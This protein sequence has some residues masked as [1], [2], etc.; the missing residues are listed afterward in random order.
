MCIPR[1][2]YR[3]KRPFEAVKAPLAGLQ[4]GGEGTVAK[5]GRGEW[6]QE[7]YK[8]RFHLWA[9]R[10]LQHSIHVKG[11]WQRPLCT[12]QLAG[13]IMKPK[14]QSSGFF[15][16]WQLTEMIQSNRLFLIGKVLTPTLHGK[17]CIA[18]FSARCHFP[19]FEVNM[20]SANINKEGAAP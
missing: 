13:S 15:F 10:Y 9:F 8:Q 5:E 20:M 18:F 14:H 12:Q 6:D 11:Y 17:I 4:S 1:C 2:P 3:V 19:D 16:P 7:M